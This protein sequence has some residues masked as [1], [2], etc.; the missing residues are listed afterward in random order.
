MATVDSG[1]IS[2]DTLGVVFILSN[3]AMP[4][5]VKVGF[6]TDIEG[7]MRELE[8]VGATPFPWGCVYAA[9]VE[10]P[11]AWMRMVR[12]VY[13]K[14]KVTAPCFFQAVVAEGIEGV[15]LLAKGKEVKLGSGRKQTPVEAE[16]KSR[17]K[18]NF[19]LEML[20]IEVGAELEFAGEEAE[21]VCRVTQVKPPR[22]I[23][24]EE[25]VVRGYP[26]RPPVLS[27]IAK[28]AVLLPCTTSYR[29]P[30]IKVTETAPACWRS[31]RNSSCSGVAFGNRCQCMAWAMLSN[32]YIIIRR[33]C[34]GMTAP[35]TAAMSPRPSI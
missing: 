28:S 32:S 17:K 19:N 26:V 1:N 35:E 3:Q 13:S 29:F 4:D 5:F 8:R 6:T 15:F 31:R 12:E 33:R 14:S 21:A 7:R 16:T 22:V 10:N 23:Y 11:G 24:G 34:R 30:S 9:E 18:E 2:G 20:G 27:R 25:G